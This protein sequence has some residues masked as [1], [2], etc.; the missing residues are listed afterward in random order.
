MRRV[1]TLPGT[2]PLMFLGVIPLLVTGVASAAPGYP[3]DNPPETQFAVSYESASNA[4]T[5]STPT[6]EAP[7][8]GTLGVDGTSN[9]VLV[10]V[11]GSN[12]QVNH[13][14]I[15]RRI[16]ELAEVS[17][18][19]CVTRTVAQSDLGKGDRQV[20]PHEQ[21]TSTDATEPVD[22]SVLEGECSDSGVS[23]DLVPAGASDHRVG[24]PDTPQGKSGDA[25][26]K[27]K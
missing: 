26:G 27:N 6:A 11:V 23:S 16:H 9:D 12:G 10:S 20:R 2:L 15:V 19:G 3:V 5:L 14:Q 18:R 25:P 13:G 22:Q 17:Q 1:S 8:A 7:D 4:L 24:D 21:S